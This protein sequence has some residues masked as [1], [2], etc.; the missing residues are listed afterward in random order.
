MTFIDS[1]E[2]KICVT[3]SVCIGML[4]LTVEWICCWRAVARN[5]EAEEKFWKK[6]NADLSKAADEKIARITRKGN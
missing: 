4:I 2:F 3:V 1:I 5:R 6:F